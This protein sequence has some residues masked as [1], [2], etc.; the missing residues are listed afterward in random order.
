MRNA[1]LAGTVTMVKEPVNERDEIVRLVRRIKEADVKLRSPQGVAIASSA[2][3]WAESW[4]LPM[5]VFQYFTVEETAPQ[6]G[7]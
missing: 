4:Q 2:L 6:S 1:P 5:D 3:A 7:R